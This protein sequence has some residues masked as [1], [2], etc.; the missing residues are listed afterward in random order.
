MCSRLLLV[1]MYVYYRSAKLRHL[2]IHRAPPCYATDN[3]VS[4]KTL[5]MYSDLNSEQQHTIEKILA[6]S[7]YTIVQGMPGTGKYVF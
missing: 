3:T 4:A 5:E 7:D 2:I 6:S 1:L